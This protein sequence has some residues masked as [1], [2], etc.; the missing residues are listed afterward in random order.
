MKIS[1]TQ[2]PLLHHATQKAPSNK[3]KTSDFKDLMETIMNPPSSEASP[4]VSPPPLPPRQ[5]LQ[6]G[7]DLAATRTVTDPSDPRK[8]CVSQLEQMLDFLDF[9]GRR[10]ADPAVPVT[11]ME[12]LVDQLEERLSGLKSLHE[13][14]P[15]ALQTILSDLEITL[16]AEIAKFKRGDYA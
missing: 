12:P 4:T 14:L 1:E 10:L 6:I 2:S 5:G 3:A 7:S 16:S 8:A 13:G 11:S 15:D 9:Y